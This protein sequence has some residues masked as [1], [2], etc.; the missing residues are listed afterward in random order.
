MCKSTIRLSVG[1]LLRHSLTKTFIV[2]SLLFYTEVIIADSVPDNRTSST[3]WQS[4]RYQATCRDN[5]LL[6]TPVSRVLG[7]KVCSVG[8]GGK[9]M[10][11]LTRQT[12]RDVMPLPYKEQFSD[13]KAF[14]RFTVIDN[15][16]DG[17][18]WNFVQ[19]QDYYTNETKGYAKVFINSTN[20]EHAS[21]DWLITPQISLKKGKAYTLK[22]LAYGFEGCD[23]TFDVLVGKMDGQFGKDNFREVLARQNLNTAEPKEY[24]VPVEVETD[25]NFSFAFHYTSSFQN[26]GFFMVIDDISVDLSGNNEEAPGRV[27]DMSVVADSCGELRAKISFNAPCLTS[28]GK[29]LASLSSIVLLRESD[30]TVIHTFENPMVAERLS[31]VDSTALLGYVKYTAVPYNVEGR[32]EEFSVTA[33][34][35]EDIPIGPKKVNFVDNLDG[36]ATLSWLSPGNIGKRGERVNESKLTYSLYSLDKKLLEEGIEETSITFTDMSVTGDQS[37]ARV[38]VAAKSMAGESESVLS[39]EVITGQ[40]FT[41]PYYESF[42]NGKQTHDFYWQECNKQSQFKPTDAMSSDGDGGSIFWTALD[43][44]E[45]IKFC[46]GK[47]AICDATA[48]IMAFSYYAAPDQDIEIDVEIESPAHS[49]Q[50][51]KH[52]DYKELLGKDGWR[53]VIIDLS[54]FKDNAYVIPKIRCIGEGALTY[55]VVLDDFRFFDATDNDLAVKLLD[56]PKKAHMGDCMEIKARIDNHGLSDAQSYVLVL[57]CG[58]IE[59]ARMDG[60][61]VNCLQHQ[62][63]TM[64]VTIPSDMTGRKTFNVEIVNELDS[65][66]EDNK[67]SFSLDIYQADRPTVGNLSYTIEEAKVNL[68]WESPAGDGIFSDDFSFYTPFAVSNFGRW[69]TIDSDG[70]QTLGIGYINYPHRNDPKAFMIFRPSDVEIDLEVNPSFASNSGGQYLMSFCADPTT[71]ADGYTSD[72]LVSPSLALG[73]QQVAMQVGAFWDFI[74]G[75]IM[76]YYSD[77]TNKKEDFRFF[78]KIEKTKSGFEEFDFT[79]PDGARYFALEFL[80]QNNGALLLDKISFRPEFL[81]VKG[82]NIYR[83]NKL[84]ATTGAHETRFTDT[85]PLSS[86]R[87]YRVAAIYKEGESEYSDKLIIDVTGVSDAHPDN[88][89]IRTYKNGIIIDKACGEKV[90]IVNTSGQAVFEACGEERIEVDLPRGIYVVN[91]GNNTVKTL[92]I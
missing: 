51:A 82:Y 74:G 45:Y 87:E 50:V 6:A 25:G 29:E 70:G 49:M 23:E 46:F 33:Y 64:S 85:T 37:L 66:K 14:T 19:E 91:I 39:S 59:L 80:P 32:G 27:T 1:L 55:S 48:P 77:S 4:L 84:I 67:T 22:F 16:N 38:R 52:I 31:F 30:N 44:D 73:S 42:P 13:E 35:G 8:N 88:I 5:E 78:G 11:E 18:T 90:S 28:S 57:K 60:P 71:T 68:S 69:N 83:D 72:W 17:N 7:E 36:T 53:R 41:L 58:D 47:F 2:L 34:I 92:V 56:C 54:E 9:V 15:D 43:Y 26:N 62:D 12:K 79:L 20:I 65:Y 76:L 75:D 89:L 81:E 10:T 61:T 21:D 40:P 24:T 3:L 86:R 63:V